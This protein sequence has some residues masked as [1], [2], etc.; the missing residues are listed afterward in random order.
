MAVSCTVFEIKRDTVLVEKRQFFIPLVFNL[1]N[2]LERY[3]LFVLKVPLNSN[4]S[5]SLEPYEFLAQILIQT[6]RVHELLGGAKIMPGSSSLCNVRLKVAIFDQ[7]LGSSRV[8]NVG[9]V[10]CYEQ[11]SAGPWQIVAHRWSLS[12][13]A[14]C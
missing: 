10:M 1:H 13:V 7:C 3:R 12:P 2:P 11:T 4:Q 6:V 8:V 9:T 14:I 5:T